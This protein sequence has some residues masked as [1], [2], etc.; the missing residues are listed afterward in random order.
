MVPGES[1]SDKVTCQVPQMING[2]S[3]DLHHYFS[4]DMASVDLEGTDVALTSDLFEVINY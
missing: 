2:Y 4:Y 1:D 3:I